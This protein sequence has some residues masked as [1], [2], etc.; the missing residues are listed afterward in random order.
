[1]RRNEGAE[2][3]EMR[4]KRDEEETEERDK[5]ESEKCSVEQLQLRN[6]VTT[7]Q[8]SFDLKVES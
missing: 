4:R 7:E 8:H 3:T 6:S 2:A 5:K 1:M